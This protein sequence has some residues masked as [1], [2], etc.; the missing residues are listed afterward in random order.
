MF[1]NKNLFALI[2]GMLAYVDFTFAWI[3]I[4]VWSQFYQIQVRWR[5]AS[6]M[7]LYNLLFYFANDNCSKY[8]GKK[9]RCLSRV[10]LSV[11]LVGV[12]IY[13]LVI[14]PRSA[15]VCCQTA[16]V[17]VLTQK[18]ILLLLFLSVSGFLRSDQFF[19][20]CRWESAFSDGATGTGSSHIWYRPVRL[21]FPV[22]TLFIGPPRN[23]RLALNID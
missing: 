4:I 14:C 23:V 11:F 1:V 3:D 20:E 5:F 9:I 15:F 13:D 8:S 21:D 10:P 18:Q 19:P 22:S 12:S 2:F 7:A 17:V 16:P 6:L